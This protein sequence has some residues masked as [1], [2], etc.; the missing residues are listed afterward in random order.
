M[1]EDTVGKKEHGVP[2]DQFKKAVCIFDVTALSNFIAVTI[3]ENSRAG[4]R[5]SVYQGD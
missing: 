4:S 1:T 5:G 2:R 3:I